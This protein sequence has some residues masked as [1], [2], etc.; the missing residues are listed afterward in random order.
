MSYICNRRDTHLYLSTKY[1]Q[2]EIPIFKALITKLQYIY[3]NIIVYHCLPY[4]IEINP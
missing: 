2:Q 3:K 1:P 4:N